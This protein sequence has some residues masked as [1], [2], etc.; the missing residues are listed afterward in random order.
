MWPPGA[1]AF[2]RLPNDKKGKALGTRLSGHIGEYDRMSGGI[3]DGCLHETT[4]ST[5]YTPVLHK[6]RQGQDSTRTWDWFFSLRP[7]ASSGKRSIWA[8]FIQNCSALSYSVTVRTPS[9]RSWD[10]LEQLLVNRKIQQV[11]RNSLCHDEKC[12]GFKGLSFEMSLT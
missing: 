12:V 10:F 3:R 6:W 7:C 5:N 4:T 11:R 9:S 2:S 8:R 1:R